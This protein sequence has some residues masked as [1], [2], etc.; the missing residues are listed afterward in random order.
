MFQS[1]AALRIQK[2]IEI[3]ICFIEQFLRL[4]MIKSQKPVRLIQPVLPQERR[5]FSLQGRKVFIAVHGYERGI[6]NSFQ[7]EFFIESFRHIQ[8]LI[9]CLLGSSDDHLRA[10]PRGDEPGSTFI[11]LDLLPVL[12]T[13]FLDDPH[14]S[15]Y[16]LSGLMRSEPPQSFCRREFYIDAHTIRQKSSEADQSLVCPGDSLYVDIS[17]EIIYMPQF[18]QCRIDQFHRIIRAFQD[19]GTQEKPFDII[20]PVKFYCESAYLVRRK[21]CAHDVV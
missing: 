4:E 18:I 17:L 20:S 5:T 21:G 19:A 8:D 7:V 10:L 14:R 15:K 3:R 13:L 1:P 12:L 11:Q 6:K 2:D 9:V 16:I